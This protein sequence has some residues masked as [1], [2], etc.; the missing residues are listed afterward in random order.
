MRIA[1]GSSRVTLGNP[2]FLWMTS[3][4]PSQ[5]LIAELLVRAEL[6]PFSG[7]NLKVIRLSAMSALC[8]VFL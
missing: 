4:E 6:W 7:R 1:I 3:L 2:A 8:V 5:S